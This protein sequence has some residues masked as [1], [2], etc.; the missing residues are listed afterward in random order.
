M[1]ELPEVLTIACQLQKHVTDRTIVKV[2]P[3]TKQHKFCWFNGEPG[4][5]DG[6]LRGKR[7]IGAEGHGIFVEILFEEGYRLSFNDGVNVRLMAGEKAP[8]DYHLFALLDDGSALSFSVAMYGGIILHRDNYYNEYYEK[9]RD[10]VSPFSPE[11]KPYFE[12]IIGGAKPGLSAKA[13]LAAEQRFPGIGNGVLQ[14]IL[15]E[16]RIHPKRKLQ[17]LTKED[18]DRLFDCTVSV[19]RAMT[20]QGGRD[21]ERDIFGIP[22]RY[23]TKM[24]KLTWAAPCPVCNGTITK[25]AY[26]GGSV[27]YC[28][29]CQ[30]K[31]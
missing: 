21:T 1:L 9:S 24:S 29:V 25:E 4:D 17:T 20:D 18:R 2:L 14:D 19:L 23:R 27:Y 26:M 28:P 31:M 11:F 16:A 13:L 30:P 22:G 5:Y 7:I 3:P 8:K 15:F 10:A 6:V 12:K